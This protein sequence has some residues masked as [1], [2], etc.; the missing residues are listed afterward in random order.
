MTIS[1]KI[2]LHIIM[3]TSVPLGRPTVVKLV[4]PSTA[5][6]REVREQ[7]GDNCLIVVRWYEEAQPLDVPALRAREWFERHLP[8]ME[9][10]SAKDHQVAYEGYNEVADT[11]APAYCAF[12]IERLRLMNMYHLRAVVG[13]WSVGVPDIPT[14]NTYTPLLVAAQRW[15]HY[16]GLHEYAADMFDLLDEGRWIVGRFAH[17][18]VA[19]YL[20]GHRIVITECGLDRI[21]SRGQAGWKLSNI[22]PDEYIHILRIFGAFYDYYPQVVGACVFQAGSPDPQW[23]AFDVV[24]LWPRVVAQYP[25]APVTRPPLPQDETATDP[26]TLADKVRWWQEEATRELERMGVPRD[27]RAMQIIYGLIDHN[28]GLLY[29]LERALKE[30]SR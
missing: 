14:W 1:N 25:D 3:G 30:G 16:I 9:A 11:Q 7:V 21:G 4:D 22:T 6:V 28:D 20:E 5:Y 26:P 12:E 24:D 10:I 27:S 2:G 29:R 13:N 15:G 17:P 8:Q 19:P 18:D 23:D